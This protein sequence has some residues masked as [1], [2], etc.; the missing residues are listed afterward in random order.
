MGLLVIQSVFDSFLK[1]REVSYLKS[2]NLAVVLIPSAL[3]LVKEPSEEGHELEVLIF[4][5]DE[6]SMNMQ[7]NQDVRPGPRPAGPPEG[8]TSSRHTSG[9]LADNID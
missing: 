7:W 4:F 2:L 1:G 9:R 3:R 8:P 6:L 5:M